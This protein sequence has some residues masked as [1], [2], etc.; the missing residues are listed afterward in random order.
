MHHSNL[1][2]IFSVSEDSL[3]FQHQRRIKDVIF[4]PSNLVLREASGAEL[5]VSLRSS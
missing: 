3:A 5:L 2:C 4:Q 1:H